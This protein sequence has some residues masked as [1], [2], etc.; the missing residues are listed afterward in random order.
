MDEIERLIN[1]D[2]ID[3]YTVKEAM[4]PTI[5]SERCEELV[6]VVRGALGTLIDTVDGEVNN[7]GESLYAMAL[8]AFT[9]ACSVIDVVEDM[10][11]GMDSVRLLLMRG[12]AKGGKE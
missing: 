10:P 2:M 5:G 8:A 9:L 7:M 1:H 11:G 12:M 4:R 3:L 6:E